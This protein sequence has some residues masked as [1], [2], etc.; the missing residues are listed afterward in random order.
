MSSS[1]RAFLDT[2]AADNDDAMA[3]SLWTHLTA[4]PIL[5]ANVHR[6]LQPGRAQNIERG[7]RADI[8]ESCLSIFGQQK[9][10][11]QIVQT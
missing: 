10:R 8:F 7:L 5:L 6:G 9:K 1:L 4:Q 11:V 2:T 3:A